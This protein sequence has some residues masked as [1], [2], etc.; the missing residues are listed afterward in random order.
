SGLA[1]SSVQRH[2]HLFS[3]S[4]TAAVDAEIL[5]ANP[6][7]RLALPSGETD[8]M[9]FLTQKESGTLLA[10]FEP[11]PRAFVSLLLGT[12]LRYGE[13]AGLQHKRLDLNRGQL[14]VAEVWDDKTGELKAYPK[15]RKIRDVPLPD[16]VVEQIPEGDG[17]VF[18]PMIYTNWR[19]RVWLPALERS[20]L[21]HVRPHDLR[22]TYASR[23][24]ESG[25]S[26]FEIGARL[27]HVSPVT[28]Q[29]YSH[30][31][32]IDRTR[33]LRALPDPRVGQT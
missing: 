12:G 10:S 27:G 31:I 2:L 19:K 13:G 33:D 15:G 26:L 29:R 6:A 24:A 25:Y 18:G 16:W 28:T 8:E 14:R 1:P 3:A 17:L 11:A 21:G 20:G 7:A 5:V 9:R 30:L 23:L 22:H 4:L 32:P